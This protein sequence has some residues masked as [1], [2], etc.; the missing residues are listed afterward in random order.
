MTE[1]TELITTTNMI[2]KSLNP[3]NRIENGTHAILGNANRPAEKEFT[4]LPK[5]LNFTMASPVTNPIVIEIANP[6]PSLHKVTPIINDGVAAGNITCQ[7]RRSPFAPMFLAA[8]KYIGGSF[9][10]LL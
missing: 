3:K 7:K 9:R 6:T 8:R 5:P 1:K 2:P 4:V 10:I